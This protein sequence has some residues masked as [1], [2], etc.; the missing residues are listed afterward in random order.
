MFTQSDK[1]IVHLKIHSEER[2]FSCYKGA[3]R[4][5][6]LNTPPAPQIG[7]QFLFRIIGNYLSW[8]KTKLASL[9]KKPLKEI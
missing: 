2:E 9:G 7:E 3:R 4:F 8:Q 1:L 6:I 5:L